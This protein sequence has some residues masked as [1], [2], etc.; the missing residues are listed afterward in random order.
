MNGASGIIVK[1]DSQTN[2]E[3]GC[4]PENCK[5]EELLN[6][7][8]INIDKPSGPTSHQVTDYVKKILRLGKAGHSGT[9]DPKVTGV[10]PIA[11]GRAT[12]IV[13]PLLT[14]GKRYVAVMHIHESVNE[15]KLRKACSQFVGRIEQLPPVRSNVK[16]ILRQRTVYSLELTEIEEKDVLFS[17]SCEAGTYIRKLIHDMGKKLGCGAHM[18]D[19][20]RVGVGPFD[21]KTLVTLHDLADAYYY[22]TQE[23]ND[24]FIRH[25]I[26]PIEKAV[27]HLPKLWVMDNAV[28]SLCHG[29]VLHIPGISRLHQNI[30]EGNLVAVMTLKDEL[31]GYGIAVASSDEI[32]KE[33]HGDAVRLEKVF[34]VPGTYLMPRSPSV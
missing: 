4:R 22:Y 31:V 11:V 1:L 16:R 9:L 19:L 2:P 8:I 10:L 26:Q 30:S 33:N 15:D 13:Q 27:E 25:C 17:V 14:A 29:A 24:K 28:E 23:G 34:M 3:F 20:R 12:R 6:Y 5:T 32:M 7:G 18:V 21:E